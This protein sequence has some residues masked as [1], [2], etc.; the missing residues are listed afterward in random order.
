MDCIAQAVSRK[1]GSRR[2]QTS[3]GA[4]VLISSISNSQRA[5]S[6]HKRRLRR[7]GAVGVVGPGTGS[8]R[9]QPVSDPVRNRLA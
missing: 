9:F 6:Q 4:Q 1:H 7:A 2:G 5:G 8:V 3:A